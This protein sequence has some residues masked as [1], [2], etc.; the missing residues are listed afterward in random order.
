MVRTSLVL[1]VAFLRKCKLTEEW[2][3]QPLSSTG[4]KKLTGQLWLLPAED[5]VP[6]R[7]YTANLEQFVWYETGW[8]W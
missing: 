6:E 2:F 5:G 3:N 4:N 8:H 7:D 1:L